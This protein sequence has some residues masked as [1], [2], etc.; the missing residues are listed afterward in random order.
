MAFSIKITKGVP[1]GNKLQTLKRSAAEIYDASAVVLTKG[2]K[3][4][5]SWM[6]DRPWLFHDEETDR[7]NFYGSVT[8]V[9][10]HTIIQPECGKTRNLEILFNAYIVS[11]KLH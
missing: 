3:F 4:Q 5:T 9:R 1:S 8:H 2:L 10:G 6:K 7:F 11:I